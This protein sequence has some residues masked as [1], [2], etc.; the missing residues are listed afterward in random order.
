MWLEVGYVYS[1]VGYEYLKHVCVNAV[2]SRSLSV[3]KPV[4]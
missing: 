2:Y 1:I 4:W 3:L